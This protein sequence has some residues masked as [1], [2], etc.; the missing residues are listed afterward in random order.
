MYILQP[1]YAT[2]PPQTGGLR[3]RKALWSGASLRFVV[4]L[5]LA[6]GAAAIRSKTIINWRVA[7]VWR[8]KDSKGLSFVVIS[9]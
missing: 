1:Q 2:K 6:F 5:A 9:A 7:C 4:I 8:W 3:M